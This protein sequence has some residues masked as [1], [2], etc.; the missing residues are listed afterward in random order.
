M[1][2]RWPP[3]GESYMGSQPD[4]V[5]FASDDRKGQSADG[6]VIYDSENCDNNC[7]LSYNIYNLINVC[8]VIAV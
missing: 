1:S 7:V 5:E 8:I 2:F 3:E 4:T 6:G